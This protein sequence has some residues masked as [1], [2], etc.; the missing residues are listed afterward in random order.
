MGNNHVRL[1]LAQVSPRVEPLLFLLYI[2]D[3][4]AVLDPSTKCQL[5]A[6]SCLVYRDIHGP[7]D[8][9]VVQRDLDA[10]EQWS[11]QW[12]MLFNA[13]K[14]NIMSVSRSRT[15]L[16]GFYQINNTILNCVDTA[17]YLGVHLSNNMG[18]SNHISSGVKKANSHLGFLRRNPRG[19]PQHLKRIAYVTLV[20]YLL[21]YSATI[22]DPHLAKDKGVLEAVQ[23][24]AARWIQGNYSSRSSVNAR[25]LM[26]SLRTLGWIPLRSAGNNSA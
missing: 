9:I 18:W 25:A 20:R 4:P 19:C 24:R 23:R 2:N 13:T 22:W 3:L 15:P 10:L 26:P 8:Q 12:G 7:E 5:F 21:E 6:D 17:T 11:R 16:Q 1:K 14:C